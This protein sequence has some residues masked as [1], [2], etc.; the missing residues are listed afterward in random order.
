[1]RNFT[2]KQLLHACV[3]GLLIF[4][5]GVAAGAAGVRINTTA[6][7]PLGLWRITDQ[8]EKGAYASACVPPTAP[9]MAV[10]IER[11][12]LPDGSCNGGYAPLLKR[13][14]AVAGDTVTLTP[15]A[16]IVN[17]VPLP[18][19]A[20]LAYRAIDPLPAIARG[21]YTVGQGEYWLLATDSPR[22]FDS[23]YFGPLRRADIEHGMAPLLTFTRP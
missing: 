19:S 2:R 4:L 17:G 22:S 14:V 23:R 6:S 13:I 10:A 9:M 3:P 18:N 20:T 15:E 21:D 12:Y 7:L 8:I 5:L 16:V 11:R 1:M